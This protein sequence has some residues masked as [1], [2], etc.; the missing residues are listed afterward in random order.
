[1]TETKAENPK[2]TRD[3]TMR[4]VS[5]ILPTYNR[6]NFLS[7][8][9]ESVRSQTYRNWELI[10]VDDG[11]TDDTAQRVAELAP[12]MPGP[13]KYHYQS[14]QGP[15]GARN[16]GIDLAEG[17]YLAFFDSDDV[18]LPHHLQD[19]Q[20]SLQANDDVDW[21][22]AACRVVDQATGKVLMP[23]TFYKDGRRL[24]FFNLKTRP[25]GALRIIED[26][27]VIRGM[28]CHGLAGGLQNSMI[29]KRVFADC[30]FE[31]KYRN[32][33]ED[34]LIVIRLLTK[35]LTIGYL[36]QVNVVYNVHDGHSSAAGT[37][38]S[39]EK[40]V[41]IQRAVIKGYEALTTTVKLTDSERRALNQR[42]SREYFW[43]LGYALF[44]QGGR[45]GDAIQ[46]FR[47]GI[48]LWPWDARYWKTLG[49]ALGRQL[50]AQLYILRRL[51]GVDPSFQPDSKR[52]FNRA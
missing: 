43:N 40:R 17:Q 4:V 15:Y 2:S 1:M 31:T 8:A 26:P 39:L 48:Q 38:G 46:C 21:V 29:R 33:A 52:R 41:N 35:G 36:D 7:Q 20:A 10:V 3:Q 42:L 16:T 11:S 14:N 19:C 51:A 18:W 13:V 37:C 34:R 49:L 28:I 12:S 22:Y 45:R 25:S 24:R 30:R 5:I 27:N 9:F 44:W 23:S 6:A 50:V 32:E 47:Q